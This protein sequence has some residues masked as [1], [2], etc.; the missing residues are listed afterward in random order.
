MNSLSIPVRNKLIPNLALYNRHGGLREVRTSAINVEKLIQTQSIAPEVVKTLSSI[1]LVSVRD[2][3]LNQ[4]RCGTCYLIS[5]GN[6]GLIFLTNDH[7]VIPKIKDKEHAA[8][9]IDLPII[10]NNE[11]KIKYRGVAVSKAI[12]DKQAGL[13]FLVVVDPQLQKIKDLDL[14]PL[15]FTKDGLKIDD[16]CFAIGYPAP[17]LDL[18]LTC[19]TVASPPVKSQYGYKGEKRFETIAGSDGNISFWKLM[20]GVYRN[21]IDAWLEGYLRGK[22]SVAQNPGLH[23]ERKAAEFIDQS[24]LLRLKLQPGNSGGPVFD[25]DGRVIATAEIAS[26]DF[27]DRS[28]NWLASAKRALFRSPLTRTNNIAGAI[29]ND[30]VLST[31]DRYGIQYKL[32]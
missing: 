8:F 31:L 9:T 20:A 29:G 7:V 13:G 4:Y 28:Y 19:G 1:G 26:E 10:N 18:T 32:E 6:K 30:S 21:N 14:E 16:L 15:P 17:D 2:S 24:Y 5:K 12:Y 25:K 22:M 3:E 23:E 11:Q 27:L